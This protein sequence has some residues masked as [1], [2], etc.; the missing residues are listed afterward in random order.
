ME[1]QHIPTNPRRFDLIYIG[2]KQHFLFQSDLGVFPDTFLLHQKVYCSFQYLIEN[3]VFR[4]LIVFASELFYVLDTVLHGTGEIKFS[5][6]H[7]QIFC[8]IDILPVQ[9]LLQLLR[10]ALCQDR[11]K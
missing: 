2:E 4:K 1:T 3:I 8:D 11:S 6:Q 10:N 9:A 7:W 5:A